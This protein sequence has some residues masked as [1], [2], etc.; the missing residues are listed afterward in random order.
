MGAGGR[1]Q[2]RCGGDVAPGI[3]NNGRPHT[4]VPVASGNHENQWS[5]EAM[6]TAEEAG[7]PEHHALLSSK[8][9]PPGD[10]EDWVPEV[11]RGV[12]IFPKMLSSIT[13]FMHSLSKQMGHSQFPDPSS[14][15]TTSW[16]S[17][18]TKCSGPEGAQMELSLLQRMLRCRKEA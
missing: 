9:R 8:P 17:K 12:Y 6:G 7:L 15:P 2:H 16:P 14:Q 3:W 13:L 18:E 5:S 10:S 1:T 4:K 11:R